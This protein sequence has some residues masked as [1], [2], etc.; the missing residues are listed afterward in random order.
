MSY[1]R[2]LY[3]QVMRDDR[4]VPPFEHHALPAMVGAG[5]DECVSRVFH[6]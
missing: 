4:A 3:S 6:L 1:L 5:D 2:E